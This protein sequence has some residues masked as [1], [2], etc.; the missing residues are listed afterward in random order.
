MESRI[1][2]VTT[3]EIGKLEPFKSEYD[4][5][6]FLMNHPGIM[7]CWDSDSETAP[8]L[9][10]QQLS[11]IKREGGRGII[12]LIGIVPEE[13]DY[14]L[15][16]FELKKGEIVK[17]NVEQL[18]SYREGWPKNK[19][20]QEEIRLR[21]K[22]IDILGLSQDRI[23]EILR[24]PRG[25]I[26]G[27]SFSPEAISLASKNKIDGIRLARFMSIS[28][29]EYY[30]VIEDQIGKIVSSSS[31]SWADLEKENLIK[32]QD[33]FYLDAGDKTIWAR[34]DRESF[35][36]P[37]KKFILEEESHNLIL[38]NEEEIRSKVHREDEKRTVERGLADLKN[39][40]PLSFTVAT[41]L[42]FIGFEKEH[43]RGYWT[44]GNYWKLER[45]DE[46]IKKLE[47]RL[48]K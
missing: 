18:I 47:S 27:S 43:R 44:P 20:A 36:R 39:S 5:E 4:M 14:L 45:S 33:R 24:R 31:K 42:A 1:W 17:D 7:G 13:K 34:P 21:I 6:A 3:E 38:E 35:D 9:L 32:P 15:K 29:K 30:V 23:K 8:R 11:T 46:T 28:S 41:C 10:W 37:G 2:K 16:I 19:K 22:E 26:V 25:V 48:E 12:D 40:K